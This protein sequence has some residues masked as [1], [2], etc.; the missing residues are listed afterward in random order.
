M[1]AASGFGYTQRFPP[2]AEE[3]GSTSSLL[4]IPRTVGRSHHILVGS[5]L[6]PRGTRRQFRKSQSI[7]GEKAWLISVPGRLSTPISEGAMAENHL[8][9]PRREEPTGGIPPQSAGGEQE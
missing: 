9:L 2:A 1:S 8:S 6:Q 4:P 7:E 3:P 5:G